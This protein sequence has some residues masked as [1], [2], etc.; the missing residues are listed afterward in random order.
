MVLLI[1][2]L[3]W[4]IN[5]SDNPLK[6]RIPNPTAYLWYGGRNVLNSVYLIIQI[7]FFATFGDTWKKPIYFLGFGNE[8]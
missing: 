4:M 5:M 8:I 3:S 6:L 7:W 2:I 1:P